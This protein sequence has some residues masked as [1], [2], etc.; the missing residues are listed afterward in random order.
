M[1]VIANRLH[2]KNGIHILTS[3]NSVQSVSSSIPRGLR[4][5]LGCV[6]SSNE[7]RLIL[8]RSV[9]GLTESEPAISSHPLHGTY[10]LDSLLELLLPGSVIRNVVLLELLS[11]MVRRWRVG[12][13][14][15]LPH[16]VTPQ[17]YD[18][19]QQE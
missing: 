12:S 9:F 1:P 16:V 4:T 15:I 10:F 6:V 18:G 5:A 13:V 19:N 14:V 3:S 17:A 2:K 11:N 8:F 7:P